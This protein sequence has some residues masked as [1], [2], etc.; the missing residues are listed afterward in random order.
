MKIRIRDIVSGGIRV[1]HTVKAQEIGLVNEEFIDPDAVLRV[2]ADLQKVNN[3]VLAKASVVFIAENHCARCLER[4][5]RE[6]TMD[7]DI[8]FEV[9]P[10]DEWLDLGSRVREELLMGVM[11]RALCRDDCRGLCPGCGADLNTEECECEAPH[12]AGQDNK[13]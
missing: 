2:V 10:G 4:L 6:T 9:E 8:D 13:E 12:N 7:L 5:S 1:D 3:F 11:P